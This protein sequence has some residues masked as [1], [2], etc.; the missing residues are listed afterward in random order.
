MGVDGCGIVRAY[1]AVFWKLF[2]VLVAVDWDC[3]GYTL[4]VRGAN[5]RQ[6]Q[7]RLET[8]DRFANSLFDFCGGDCR[9]LERRVLDYGEAH[10]GSS[11]YFIGPGG[12]CG[13]RR[14]PDWSQMRRGDFLVFGRDVFAAVRLRIAGR[15][16][17]MAIVCRNWK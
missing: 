2:L 17:A 10:M 12:L 9:K 7:A 14:L 16:G 4:A 3:V 6:W 1:R 13:R 15:K 11:H 5:Y 8:L